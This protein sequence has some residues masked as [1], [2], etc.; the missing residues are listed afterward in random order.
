[1]TGIDNLNNY[2]DV[3]L[4]YVRFEELRK[5]SDSIDQFTF[6]KGGISYKEIVKFVFNKYRPGIIVNLAPQAGVRYSIENTDAYIQSNIMGY[7]N[8]LEACLHSHNEV[9]SNNSDYKGVEHLVYV[10]SSSVY[11][12]N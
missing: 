3:S 9:N 2:Y 5:T 7:F 6:I 8:I 11:G 12:T 10:S 4:K 1:M